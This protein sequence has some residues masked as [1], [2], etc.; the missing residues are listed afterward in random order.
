MNSKVYRMNTINKEI[1][2]QINKFQ[3]I[4]NKQKMNQRITAPVTN[5]K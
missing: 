1:N 2:K 4:R 3:T 5:V